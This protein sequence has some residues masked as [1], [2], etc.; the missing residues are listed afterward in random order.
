MDE[1]VSKEKKEFCGTAEYVSPE[2][3]ND[4]KVGK[5]A[6]LWALG[7]ILYQMLVGKPPFKGESEYLTFQ[8]IT[9]YPENNALVF[10]P[11]F[12]ED[13]KV[14]SLVFDLGFLST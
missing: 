5:G 1:T 9:H 3:L 7:C 2:V 14:F 4:E 12:N 6:D 11:I 8:L 13:A 10:P